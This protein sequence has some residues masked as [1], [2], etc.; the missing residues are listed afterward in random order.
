MGIEL[1]HQQQVQAADIAEIKENVLLQSAEIERLHDGLQDA[2][3]A[4]ATAASNSEVPDKRVQQQQQQQQQLYVMEQQMLQ[5]SQALER[6]RKETRTARTTSRAVL[7]ATLAVGVAAV[8]ALK[9]G[10]TAG[11]NQQPK[12]PVPVS[13][14]PIGNFF[15]ETSPVV[16]S[17]PIAT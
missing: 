4:A 14:R 2:A 1:R 6:L 5:H 8:T 9:K 16:I 13:K 15:A 10:A 3:E 17:L 12:Q 7:G 11:T